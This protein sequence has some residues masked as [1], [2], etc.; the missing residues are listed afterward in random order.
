MRTKIV[1]SENKFNIP[2]G[3]YIHL[4]GYV[5]VPNTKGETLWNTVSYWIYKDKESNLITI[6]DE[7]DFIKNNC[8]NVILLNNCK[9]SVVGEEYFKVFYN[10]EQAKFHRLE[11]FD[12]KHHPAKL[13]KPYRD[14]VHESTNLH[15]QFGQQ[16]FKTI[17]EANEYCMKAKEYLNK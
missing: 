12:G 13:L 7:I 2:I 11:F 3:T 4:S 15:S 6:P 10:E 1:I 8:K 9:F 17:D 16:R 5:D 14:I